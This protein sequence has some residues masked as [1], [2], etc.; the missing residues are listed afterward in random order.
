MD[1]TT[2]TCYD[3]L[4]LLAQQFF[5]E[6]GIPINAK[7]APK[8]KS[9]FVS[10][11]LGFFIRKFNDKYDDYITTIGKTIYLP[12]NF[13]DKDPIS[14]IDILAHEIKHITDSNKYGLL[15]PIGYLF[16]QI[17]VVPLV[18]LA[19]FFPLL[20]I[21]AILVLAPWPAYFRYK[22]ELNGY[23]TNLLIA[24]YVR[25]YSDVGIMQTKLWITK[26]MTERWYYF[27]WPFKG[28]V[29]NDLENMGFKAEPYYDELLLF[30]KNKGY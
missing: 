8:S 9:I 22:I 20:I 1:T 29:L 5:I 30:F 16:P 12:D 18:I 25:K 4:P 10:N 27:A 7:L 21:P 6:F 24:T 23:R 19:I 2:K 28:W 15:Y 14:T 3:K 11:I 17:L 13:Y 26:Q